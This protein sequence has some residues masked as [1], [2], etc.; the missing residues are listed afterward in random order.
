MSHA[1]TMTTGLIVKSDPKGPPS[2]QTGRIIETG[3]YNCYQKACRF[4]QVRANSLT[5]LSLILLYI[6]PEIFGVVFFSFVTSARFAVRPWLADDVQIIPRV[7]AVVAR[8]PT[9]GRSLPAQ[10]RNCIED[11][12]Q[13]CIWLNVLLEGNITIVL[14]VFLLYTLSSR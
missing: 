6:E 7:Q 12:E 1:M 5:R 10:R 14:G 2:D 4:P 3:L 8:M 13:G 11:Q 9:A